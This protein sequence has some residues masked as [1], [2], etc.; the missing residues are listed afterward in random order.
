MHI[1]GLVQIRYV[2]SHSERAWLAQ[3]A[4]T[5]SWLAA[6]FSSG[7]ADARLGVQVQL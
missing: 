1:L 7:R 2:V 6:A 4:E 3:V 5:S